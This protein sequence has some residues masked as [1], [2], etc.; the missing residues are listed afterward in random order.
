[1]RD[2]FTCAQFTCTR[3]GI[4]SVFLFGFGSVHRIKKTEPTNSLVFFGFLSKSADFDDFH[5]K[6][7]KKYIF[8][9]LCGR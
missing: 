6:M 7:F 1:M 9:D 4:G 5:Q 8:I 3:D 2:V